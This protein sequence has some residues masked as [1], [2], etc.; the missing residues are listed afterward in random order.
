MVKNIKTN[1]DILESLLVFWQSSSEGEKVGEIYIKSIVD[2]PDMKYLYN[3][4]FNKESARKVLS[5]I[6][7]RELISGGTKT[8]MR[9]WNNNM[10]MLE[11]MGFTNMMINPI[12]TLH[13]E[14]YIDKVNEFSKNKDI[15]NIEIIFLPG[16]FQEYYLDE[17]KLIINFFKITVDLFDDE[18]ITID[19]KDFN[20]YIEEKLIE[21][22]S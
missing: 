14:K 7:N 19:G 3:E 2:F 13:G 4:E 5:A 9:Y 6:S 11:D 18:K 10:W 22:V 20:E 8:E 12:K 16:H 1:L 17:N 15:E 21:L